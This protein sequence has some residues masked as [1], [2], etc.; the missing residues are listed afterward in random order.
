MKALISISFLAAA[1]ACAVCVHAQKKGRPAGQER[2]I[3]FSSD[4]GDTAY[5]KAAFCELY[6]PAA[7]ARL[8]TFI[9]ALK[10]NIYISNNA[11]HERNKNLLFFVKYRDHYPED[12]R[13]EWLSVDY[14]ETVFEGTDVAQWNSGVKDDVRSASNTDVLDWVI[15]DRRTKKVLKGDFAGVFLR[16]KGIQFYLSETLKRFRY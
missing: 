1:L 14:Y 9:A 10:R 5:H 2:S 8:D 11:V 15:Y 4:T 12:Y 6:V 7:Q 13:I 16:E 3:F